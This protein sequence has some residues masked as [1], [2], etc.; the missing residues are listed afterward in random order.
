MGDPHGRADLT[1]A[2]PEHLL[3]P[4]AAAGADCAAA[5][6]V[7]K[8]CAAADQQKPTATWRFNTVVMMRFPIEDVA[9]LMA[10]LLVVLIV[11]L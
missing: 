9:A 1:N 7:K 6:Q 11:L 4:N 2:L 3:F 8:P 10:A 5:K